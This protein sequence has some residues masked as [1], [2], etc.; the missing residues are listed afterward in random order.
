MKNSLQVLTQ[1]AI[2]AGIDETDLSSMLTCLDPR[3]E[4]YEKD[5][6]ALHAGDSPDSLGLVTAG[7]VLVIQ[8]DFRGNRNIRMRK[9]P[10]QTFAESFACV[11]DAV[12]DVSVV[13]EEDSTLMWLNVQRILHTCPSACS[14]HSLMIRNLLSELGA[15]NLRINEKLKHISNRTTRDKLLS[16]LSSEAQRQG[17][18][19]FTIPY[20]RQELADYLSVERSAM[21]V[22]LSKMQ[23]DGLLTFKK[24]VFHLQ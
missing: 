9:M 8:E 24:N 15:N 14:H 7:T 5:E 2:F 18:A 10:G 21:S 3:T 6:Y 13:A 23:R 19:E 20:N 1:A 16:Y 22:E 17:C 11:P 12:A 4:T